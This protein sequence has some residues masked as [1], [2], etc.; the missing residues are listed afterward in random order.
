MGQL[1]HRTVLRHVASRTG[2]A[3]A[4]DVLGL[5][6]RADHEHSSVW[7]RCRNPL[8]RLET[9]HVRHPQI[10]DDHIWPALPRELDAPGAV[11]GLPDDLR[12]GIGAE[13]KGEQLPKDGVVVDE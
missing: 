4:L 1:R 13:H 12:S 8:C 6:G 9:V 5:G 7:D 10:H 2:S 11:A 3:R